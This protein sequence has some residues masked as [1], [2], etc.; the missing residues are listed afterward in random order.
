[1]MSQLKKA[2]ALIASVSLGFYF[3]N[4]STTGRER[5]QGFFHQRPKIEDF[6]SHNGRFYT[7]NGV[8]RTNGLYNYINQSFERNRFMF[9]ADLI[10]QTLDRRRPKNNKIFTKFDFM[11][12]SEKGSWQFLFY[13][14]FFPY[15]FWILYQILIWK[16][17]NKCDKQFIKIV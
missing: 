15:L 9:S 14:D 1:M 13:V 11:K 7:R 8:N 10:E 3:G 2:T 16:R 12:F 5:I 17:V 6:L 4:Q